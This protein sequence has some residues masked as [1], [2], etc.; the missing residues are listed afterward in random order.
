MNRIKNTFFVSL[1]LL[2]FFLYRFFFKK[3]HI[4]DLKPI[5]QRYDVRE[6]VKNVRYLQRYKKTI[7]TFSI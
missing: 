5:I 6:I 7:G 2:D 3:I 4:N 1:S